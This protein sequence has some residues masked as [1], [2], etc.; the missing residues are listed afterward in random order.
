PAAVAAK[1]DAR[2]VLKNSIRSLA[3]IVQGTTTVTDAQKLELGL[4]VQAAPSPNPPPSVQPSL[5]VVSVTGRTVRIRLH[6][7]SGDGK[8]TKPAGVKSAA[9]C[10]FVGATAPSD[11]SAYKW[12][13]STGRSIVDITF[14]ESAAPGTQVWLTAMWMNERQQTGPACEPIGATIAYGMSAVA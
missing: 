3:Y 8:R 4:T 14:P 9:I 10:S 7:A 6:D 5:D 13:G 11:P 1:N 12:E 2:D